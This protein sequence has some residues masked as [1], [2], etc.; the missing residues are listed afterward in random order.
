MLQ[1]NVIKKIKTT[2]SIDN[3]GPV[4]R[5][6]KPTVLY[7]L[8]LATPIRR[9]AVTVLPT[10][11][12]VPSA[13]TQPHLVPTSAPQAPDDMAEGSVTV[14][15]PKFRGN[16]DEDADA[17]IK[18]FDRYIRYKEIT[19]NGKKLNL[20]A[21]LLTDSA[22]DWYESLPTDKKSS[23]D[24]LRKAFEDR[25]QSPDAVRYQ[26]AAQIFTRKQG[27]YETVDQFVVS[28]QKSAKLCGADNN[29]LQ[30]AIINGLHPHV[31]AAVTLAKPTSI[32]KLL[33]VARLAELTQHKSIGSDSVLSQQLSEMQAEMRR[34]STKVEKAVTAT[35]QSRSPTPERRVH[36]DR[37]QS[38]G[39][40]A[41]QYF[42]RRTV[43][44]QY[45]NDRHRQPSTH[46]LFYGQHQQQPMTP[47]SFQGQQ[48]RFTS[49]N[50]PCT[51]RAKNH[52]N[53]SFCP[54]R[55]TNKRCF[56]FNK[57]GHF[58]SAC[59]AVQKQY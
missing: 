27:D 58:R 33:E 47:S 34:L 40:S 20:L 51:R 22:G 6:N 25:Y 32:E 9:R 45:T 28:M 56:F 49:R 4:H 37:P 57:P 5:S 52:N 50:E 15:P 39:Q 1:H 31:S 13:A 29:I 8:D 12:V 14:Q 18:T 2:D 43:G 21:V 11:P 36:F 44:G 46:K 55:D 38:P 54:A 53:N 30:F 35:V 17:F 16:A 24:A 59:Y 19:D 7:E 26:S 23:L 3:K 10:P 42:R 48:R 41:D